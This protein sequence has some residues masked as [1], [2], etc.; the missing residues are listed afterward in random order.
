MG[1]FKYLLRKYDKINTVMVIIEQT[2][3][4]CKMP[5]RKRAISLKLMKRIMYKEG[6]WLLALQHQST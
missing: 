5:K 4:H 1:T 2:R 6:K 3:I